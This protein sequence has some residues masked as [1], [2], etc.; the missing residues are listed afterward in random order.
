MGGD[1]YS[2]LNRCCSEKSAIKLFKAKFSALTKNKWEK[3][4]KFVPVYYTMNNE[5]GDS[6]V[7]NLC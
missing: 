6:E 4:H 7:G 2:Q 5:E 1:K 3:R